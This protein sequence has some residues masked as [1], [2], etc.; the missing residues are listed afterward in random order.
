MDEP[1]Y[2]EVCKARGLVQVLGERLDVV[3]DGEIEAIQRMLEAGFHVLPPPYSRMV[4]R[5]R[6]TRGPLADVEGVLLRA[7]PNKG[8]CSLDRPGDGRVSGS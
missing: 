2:L 4:R 6:I 8:C 1:S 5:V 7:K 3:A